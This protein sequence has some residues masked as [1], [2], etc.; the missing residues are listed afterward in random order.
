M[1]PKI[2]LSGP[3]GS[4]KSTVARLLADRLFVPLYSAGAIFREEAKRQGL[5]LEAFGRLAEEDESIDRSLDEA[6]LKLLREEDAGVFE[7]RL[8]GWLAFTH[9][10]PALKV[11]LDA[12]LDVRVQRI[13]KREG[14]ADP[15]AIREAVLTRERSEA[16]RYRRLYGVD[17]RDTS[18]Y[19]L[20]VETARLS[21]EE[22]VRRILRKLR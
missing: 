9:K 7:G 20:V 4:G 19:D 12:P 3:P 21:P 22:V 10:I 11:Y 13:Q 8:T 14:S 18:F 16:K 5:S 17:V 1:S 6:M 15:T 2:T